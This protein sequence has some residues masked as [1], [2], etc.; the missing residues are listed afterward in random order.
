MRKKSIT[1]HLSIQFSPKNVIKYLNVSL[2]I[3]IYWYNSEYMFSQCL[4]WNMKST[5]D[6]FIYMFRAVLIWS[7]SYLAFLRFLS[8][9]LGLI[10]MKCD[11]L[12]EPFN[13]CAFDESLP[14]C[15]KQDY[16]V[17]FV[18]TNCNFHKRHKSHDDSVIQV[19]VNCRS[20]HKF[21]FQYMYDGVY[22]KKML[23]RRK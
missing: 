22:Y 6:G 19:F 1:S 18:V 9:D 11:W 2:T 15:T 13:I 20:Q 8:Q 7:Q 10:M 23:C 21:S 14:H 3:C 16:V 17:T 4:N 5:V 12:H